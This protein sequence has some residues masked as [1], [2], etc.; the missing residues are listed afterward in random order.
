MNNKKQK[1]IVALLDWHNIIEGV[2]ESKGTLFK[3]EFFFLKTAVEETLQWLGSIGKISLVFVFGPPP[4]I[5][6]NF[7]L[8]NSFYFLM[9]K[10]LGEATENGFRDKT[11]DYIKRVGFGLVEDFDFDV[12]CLGSGDKDFLPL[13]EKAKEKK[14]KIAYVVGSEKNLAE[15]MRKKTDKH[16][17]TGEPMV[18]IFSPIKLVSAPPGL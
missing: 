17:E 3:P 5:D 12:L 13:A 15:V 2:R 1:K 9:V 16:P 10:C 7:S 11:D 18:H 4:D 8:F 6:N 14:M